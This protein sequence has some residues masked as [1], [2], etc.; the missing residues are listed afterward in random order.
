MSEK[1][2]IFPFILPKLGT[3]R[4]EEYYRRTKELALRV[5]TD[6]GGNRPN[7]WQGAGRAAQWAKFR[8]VR[9]GE[10]LAKTDT[11]GP[12]VFGDTISWADFF[13]AI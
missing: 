5:E 9:V 11:K 4:S 1:I 12:F 2:F 8:D 10:C 3:Q 7:G 13:R 6:A